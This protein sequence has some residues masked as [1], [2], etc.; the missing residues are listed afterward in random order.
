MTASD[1]IPDTPRGSGTRDE[2][3]AALAGGAADR[4]REIAQTTRRVVQTSLGVL[5]KQNADRRRGRTVALAAAIVVLIVI[6]PPLWWLADLLVEEDRLTNI[7]GEIAVW[8]FLLCTA[9][10]SAVLMAGWVRNRR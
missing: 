6:G 1:A 9:L 10:L 8:A 2:V 7:T 3:T 4:Q 5:Q